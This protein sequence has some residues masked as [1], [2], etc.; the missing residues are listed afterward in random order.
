MAVALRRGFDSAGA[1]LRLMDLG[2]PLDGRGGELSGGQRAQVALAIALGTGA[3]ILILDEPLASLDRIA[4]QDFLAM[5]SASVRPLGS[6]VVIASH[7][8]AELEG[9]CDDIVVLAP[10]RVMLHDTIAHA[11]ATHTLVPG[12]AQANPGAVASFERPDQSRVSLMRVVGDGAA[13][14]DELVLGYLMA[15]RRVEHTA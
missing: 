11:R 14:L 8:V 3:P 6:T 5:L 12:D 1:R 2:I 9:Y 4:R 7:I 13:T 15:A 10:G